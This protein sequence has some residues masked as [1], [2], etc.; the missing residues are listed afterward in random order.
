MEKKIQLFLLFSLFLFVSSFV[1]AQS[2]ATE[3][4][5]L[6]STPAVTYSQ[7]ARFVLQASEKMT[8]RN[9]AEAFN[10]ALKQKWLPQKIGPEDPADL[11]SISL[12]IMRSFEL[13]GGIMYGFTK[14]SRYAYRELT[15]KNIVQGRTD[16]DMIVTGERLIFYIGRVFSY[17][18]AMA[19]RDNSDSGD[20]IWTRGMLEFYY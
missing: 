5:T 15:Y 2:T 11:K 6:L 4:E 8:T 7:A 19:K 14:G 13:N 12:L 18:E 20:R 10:Y 3:M 1:S 17:K 16:P 9:P